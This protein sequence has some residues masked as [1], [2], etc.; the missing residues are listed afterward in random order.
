MSA[1]TRSNRCGPTATR[2]GSS[3]SSIS[4]K[5]PRPKLRDRDVLFFMTDVTGSLRW[6]LLVWI[7]WLGPCSPATAQS[8]GVLREVYT[9][10]GGNSVADLTGSANFPD[11]PT[12]EEVITVGFEAPTDVDENYGQRLSAYLVPPA[13]GSYIFWIASDDNSTLFLS[14]DDQPS[15]T[16][17]IAG[18]PAWTLPRAWDWYPDQQSA[19]VPLT[20][21]QRYYV[22]ALMKEGTGGDNLAVRWQLPDGSI[23]EPIPNERLEVF[24]LGPPQITKQPTNVTVVEGGAGTFS[25]QLSRTTGA[26]YQWLRSGLNIAGATNSSYTLFPVTLLDNNAPFRC[27][28]AN[29]GGSTNSNTAV[30][31][32]VADG[33]PPSISSVVNLGDNTAV[34]VLYSE[35]VEAAS[36][37]DRLNYSINNGVNVGGA[38]FAG[39]TR[40]VVLNTSPLIA[41]TAYTLTVNNVRDRAATPNTIAIN[42]QKTFTLDFAP[43]D[44]TAVRPGPEPIGP[45]SRRTGL[46]ISEIMYHPTNRVDGKDLEFI[47]IYNSQPFF[48]EISGYRLS[49]TVEY[50][51]STNTTIQARSYLV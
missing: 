50:T 51:F 32:V 23:E 28:I 11:N 39:D 29:P 21:G 34:T 27:L 7:V 31:T 40:S 44:I 26:T 1:L 10:I 33:T 2:R 43:L 19:P 6:L 9:G 36:G 48:E 14:T 47:E 4:G 30:L 49:G 42:S 41:G 3:R 13:S 35:P 20:G 38:T 12:L 16:Q 25:V 46:T 37:T 22:E 8:N 45:S 17:V 5:S 24:G 18:V 15:N